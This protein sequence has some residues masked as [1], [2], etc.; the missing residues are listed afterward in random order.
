VI[1]GSRDENYKKFWPHA[2]DG[3]YLIDLTY[4]INVVKE[5]EDIYFEVRSCL[6]GELQMTIDAKKIIPKL[7]VP[8]KDK[9]LK[10]LK[11]MNMNGEH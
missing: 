7:S 9:K 3:I 10:K 1:R 8:L 5:C 6:N 11:N 4:M 2:L